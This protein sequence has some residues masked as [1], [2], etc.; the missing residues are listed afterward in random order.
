VTIVIRKARPDERAFLE[1]LQR[2]V[3]LVH[4]AYREQLLTHPEIIELPASHIGGTIVAEA[5]GVVAGFAV[6][7]GHG[8]T[9]ELDGLFVEPELTERGIGRTLVERAIADARQAGATRM[10]VVSGPESAQFY[11]RCGFALVGRVQT[12]LA[13]ALRLEIVI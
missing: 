1:D 4:E 8:Q 9:M 2:R 5:D 11:Q 10:Q 12:L 3:S 7:L 6:M 13:P